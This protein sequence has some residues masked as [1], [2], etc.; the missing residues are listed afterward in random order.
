MKNLLVTLLALLCTMGAT[1]QNKKEM[2]AKRTLVAYFSCTGTTKSAAQKLAQTIGA[3]FYEIKPAKPY[4]SA[5]LNWN[6]KNSRSSVE[7]K[8]ASSRPA[9][10]SKVAD[11]GQYETI[12]VGFPIW[13]DLAPTII[14][15]FLE[16]YDF[17]GKTVVPFATSGGSG[18]AN[19]EKALRKAYPQIKWEA[20][21]LLNGRV[22]KKSLA[23]WLD[24]IK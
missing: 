22:D 19:S 16:S 8:D 7:M 11:M 13:W 18:I 21:K 15:T 24:K 10:A 5:D 14:N 23:G 17:K 20:G 4:T 6:N 3:D 2:N 9:I 1:A 12:F